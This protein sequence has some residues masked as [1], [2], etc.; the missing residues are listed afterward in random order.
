MPFSNP[1]RRF[2]L[3]CCRDSHIFER[4]NPGSRLQS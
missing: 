2:A 4:G 1:F 3:L